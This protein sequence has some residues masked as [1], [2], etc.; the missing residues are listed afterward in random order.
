MP[1]GVYSSSMYVLIVE[2]LTVGFIWLLHRAKNYIMAVA[3]EHRQKGYA[4]HL[5]KN[6]LLTL[7]PKTIVSLKVERKSRRMKALLKN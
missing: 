3:P 5:I 6:K 1:D 7:K 2:N 4:E